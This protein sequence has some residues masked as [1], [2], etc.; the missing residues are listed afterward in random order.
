M[1][2]AAGNV[3]MNE[4]GSDEVQ[5]HPLVLRLIEGKEAM[6]VDALK[7]PEGFWERLDESCQTS[8]LQVEL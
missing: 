8:R 4:R 1:G 7:S 3:N 5:R 6:L 2:N